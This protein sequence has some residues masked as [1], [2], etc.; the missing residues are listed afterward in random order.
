MDISD[1]Y[2][3]PTS[4]NMASEYS[5]WVN[6]YPLSKCFPRCKTC[7]EFMGGFCAVCEAG[8]YQFKGCY[9]QDCHSV[10]KFFSGNYNA[11]CEASCPRLRNNYQGCNC[12][13]SPKIIHSAFPIMADPNE[14]GSCQSSCDTSHYT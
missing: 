6:P 14:H 8:K 12:Q 3:F 7:G 13:T 1:C 2:Y 9:D 10:G 4:S 5:N 11:T